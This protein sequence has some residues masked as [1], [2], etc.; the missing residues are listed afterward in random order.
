MQHKKII[1]IIGSLAIT[2]LLFYFVWIKIGGDFSS[3]TFQIYL[4]LVALAGFL[5]ACALACKAIRFRFFLEKKISFSDM[6]SIVAMH[7]FWNNLLPFRSGE[8]SYLYLLRNYK[9]INSGEKITSLLTAR[10]FDVLVILIFFG[11]SVSLLSFTDIKFHFT[12]G[13]V[14]V[15]GAAFTA[16]LISL[17]LV[18]FNNTFVSFFDR[19]RSFFSSHAIF[20]SIFLDKVRESLVAFSRIRSAREFFLYYLFSTVIWIADFFFVWTAFAAAGLALS[21]PEAF[22]IAA[23]PPI[24]SIIPIQNPAGI[25]TFE[26]VIAGGLIL[27]DIDAAQALNSGILLHAELLFMSFLFFNL[28]R[29]KRRDDIKTRTHTELYA[30]FSSPEVDF[31][32]ANLSAILLSYAKGKSI[33]DIG[34]GYGTLL[35]QA[36]EKGFSA[37]GIEPDTDTIKLAQRHYKDLTILPES[38]ENHT[39]GEQ[40]DTVFLVDVLECMKDDRM[41]FQK[42][43][44]LVKKGGRLVVVVPAF[45]FLFSSRDKMLG[46]ERRY[47]ADGIL[48]M[49]A[50]SDFSIL[51]KRYWNMI[52]VLPYFLFY[53]VLGRESHVEGIRGGN[54]RGI[55]KRILSKLLFLWFRHVENRIHF[56]FGLSFI[57][58]AEKR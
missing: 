29:L 11:V 43:A 24:A 6:F 50:D 44:S 58:V 56:G 28:A 7:S 27:L 45:S 46:Y 1:K 55:A 38:L 42:A 15:L 9:E 47:N 31:R 35:S 39:G 41:A 23:F 33:L 10:I 14:F 51:H 54:A 37:V 34:C 2:A 57:C 8:L 53:K 22:F 3:F 17:A 16:A 18:F 21:F 52:S 30:S 36:K 49:F 19:V 5:Y 26:G 12:L 48:K 4:P 25:G 20:K 32:N 13:T 40:F